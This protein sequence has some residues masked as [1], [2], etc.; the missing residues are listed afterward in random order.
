MG[1]STPAA[2]G[3]AATAAP[4]ADERPTLTPT[5]RHALLDGLESDVFD[6]VVVGG[7]ITGA[8]VARDAAARG[9]RVAVL[10]ADDLAWAEVDRAAS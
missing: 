8:G 4:M 2:Q 10:E 9:L 7:G 5:S 1:A 6:V 3:R